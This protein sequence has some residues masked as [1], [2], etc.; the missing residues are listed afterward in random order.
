M[1]R[2]H[3]AFRA[4]EEAVRNHAAVLS[5]DKTGTASSHAS[6]WRTAEAIRKAYAEWEQRLPG[7]GARPDRRE[8]GDRRDN[9]ALREEVAE[10]QRHDS[11]DLGKF[12][13]RR[14]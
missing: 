7:S 8:S 3:K 5:A 2:E 13:D 6:F 14:E 11:A 4:L 10:E 9:H 1:D 12:Q